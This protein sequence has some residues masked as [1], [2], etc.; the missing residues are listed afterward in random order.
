MEAQTSDWKKTVGVVAQFCKEN[1]LAMPTEEEP[2]RIQSEKAQKVMSIWNKQASVDD[3][4]IR[5]CII[6]W[7]LFIEIKYFNAKKP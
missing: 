6:Y 7:F 5:D 1:G 2:L 3:E 4:T